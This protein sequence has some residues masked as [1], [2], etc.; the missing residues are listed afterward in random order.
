MEESIH[1]IRISIIFFDDFRKVPAA[2][3]FEAEPDCKRVDLLANSIRIKSVK[4]KA[5]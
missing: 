1:T 4:Y 5:Q 3:W 2:F